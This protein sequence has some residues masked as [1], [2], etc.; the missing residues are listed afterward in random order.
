MPG[1]FAVAR[2]AA[3]ARLAAYRAER[4]RKA[5]AHAAAWWGAGGLL[6]AVG[7]LPPDHPY[8]LAAGV[9]AG[10]R[11]TLW[12][13]T[14]RRGRRLAP[15]APRTI[16][17]LV[18]ARPVDEAVRGLETLVATLP[19]GALRDSGTSALAAAVH[20][21]DELRLV[22]ERLAA[23]A[24]TPRHPET[25][26]ARETLRARYTDGLAALARLSGAVASLSCLADGDAVAAL[27]EVTER[28]GGLEQAVRG[29]GSG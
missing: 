27:A 24:K 8:I 4:A 14:R 10:L 11:G 29:L 23:L 3:D 18:L 16:S 25:R 1:M 28:V 22:A 20:A 6:V 7:A 2:E 15:P 17:G 5:G 12:L 9:L 21:R 19:P 13:L 26:A